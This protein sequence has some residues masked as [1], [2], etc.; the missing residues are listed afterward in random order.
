ME[1]LLPEDEQ[2]RLAALTRYGILDTNPE[3]AYDDIVRLAAF[4]CG[5]PIAAVSLI[6]S[7]RQWFKSVVGLEMS[8]RETPR[9][10]AFCAHTILQTDL[11]VVPDARADK[12]FRE[13]PF[14]TG[15]P[16]IRF[17]AGAPLITTDGFSLGSLCVIDTVPRSLTADQK[18]ALSTLARQV[19]SQME[20]ARHVLLQQKLQIEQKRAEEALRRSEERLSLILRNIQDIVFLLSVE[21]GENY[22]FLFAN[23]AFLERTGLREE[24]VIGKLIEEVLPESSHRFVIQKY[25]S[26]VQVRQ[27][28][29]WQENVLY[30]T[31]QR[32]GDVV[33]TPLCEDQGACTHLIGTVHDITEQRRMQEH[34][35]RSERLVAM[36]EMVAGVAHEIN[37]PLAAVSGHAQLLGM[38][39]DPQV[40]ADGRTIQQMTDRVGRIIRSLLAFSRRTNPVD[41]RS[42]LLRPLIEG[43]LEIMRHKFRRNEVHVVLDLTEP[44][45]APVLDT[46]QIEQILLNLIDNAE[47]AL[48]GRSGD[49]VITIRTARRFEDRREWATVSVSDNGQGIPE[50]VRGRVFDP[51]FTT[52]PQGEGT[53]LGLSICFGIAQEHKGRLEVTSEV[54]V[55]TTFMLSLPLPRVSE[56]PPDGKPSPKPR[57]R[58]QR[59]TAR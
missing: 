13:N 22:R 15:D 56:T 12:R 29:R 31:G 44:D 30:Q 27:P 58:T 55:G 39:P 53:G 38:H 20:L 9:G 40:Q 42:S 46:A 49:K 59:K 57:K 47:Y 11:T 16:N 1:A 23:P 43:T 33:I 34:V 51:F 26:A 48:R 45:L 52:K 41:R 8:V 14:V 54:G 3:D 25:A 5:T 19:T 7:H 28:V 35:A 2:D 21:T 24:Q 32:V 17:Y 4:I 37:N 6:D 10:V 36:G 18:L 50:E